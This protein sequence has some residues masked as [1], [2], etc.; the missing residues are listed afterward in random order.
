VNVGKVL[1]VV[2]DVAVWAF[3]VS[4]LV[5]PALYAQWRH[6]EK[7]DQKATEKTLKKLLHDQTHQFEQDAVN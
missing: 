2:W 3:V 1:A 6:R 5:L 4:V 7:Q